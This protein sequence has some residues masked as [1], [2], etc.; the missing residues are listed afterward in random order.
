MKPR[1]VHHLASQAPTDD[2]ITGWIGFK[3]TDEFGRAVGRIEDVYRVDGA[4]TWLLLRQRRSRHFLAPVRGAIGSGG[5]VFLPFTHEVIESAPEIQPGETAS[6]EILD[7]A[8]EHY[9][10]DR[11][12]SS[13]RD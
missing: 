5:S 4:V 8:A 13:S 10:L 9:G 6:A 1:S 2:E 7:A 12:S 11:S 3:A